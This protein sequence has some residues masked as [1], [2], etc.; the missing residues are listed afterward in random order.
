MS[1]IGQSV[2]RCNMKGGLGDTFLSMLLFIY[3]YL[4]FVKEDLKLHFVHDT[5]KNFSYFKKLFLL[6]F[7]SNWQI[8]SSRIDHTG[9]ELFHENFRVYEKLKKLNLESF[10]TDDLRTFV[11]IY[12]RHKLVVLDSEFQKRKTVSFK[13]YVR[14]I[15]TPLE[16]KHKLLEYKSISRNQYDKILDLFS[17]YEDEIDFIEFYDWYRDKRSLNQDIILEDPI[18]VSNNN[19]KLIYNSDLV[20]CCEGFFSISSNVFKKDTVVFCENEGL[21]LLKNDNQYFC[22]NFDSFIKTIEEELC[23]LIKK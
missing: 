14:D 20:I 9:Y 2:F 3:K 1:K 21:S 8:S 23:I 19:L 4:D 13:I 10:F 22:K 11:P 12:H 16:I 18:E 17:K 15:H 5:D 7:P 6:K